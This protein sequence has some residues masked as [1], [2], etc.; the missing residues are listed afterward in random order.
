MKVTD[1]KLSKI[2][3]FQKVHLKTSSEDL[4]NS[5]SHS[6]FYVTKLITKNN[7][8]NQSLINENLPKLK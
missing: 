4:N 5:S 7:I 2:P 3:P 1:G 6:N 8:K